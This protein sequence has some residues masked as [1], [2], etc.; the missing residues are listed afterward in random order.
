MKKMRF[1]LGLML[2]M[3]F[4]GANV[5]NAQFV[6]GLPS[7][8]YLRTTVTVHPCGFYASNVFFETWVYDP[9]YPHFPAAAE[10]P[11]VRWYYYF[12]RT[13]TIK[14]TS[15]T[16]L[17]PYGYYDSWTGS[18]W[19]VPTASDPLTSA[20]TYAGY[21][22]PGNFPNG[23]IFY[24]RDKDKAELINFFEINLDYDNGNELKPAVFRTITIGSWAPQINSN[25][26][27]RNF[28]SPTNIKISEMLNPDVDP[29][30]KWFRPHMDR[31][32]NEVATY[33]YFDDILPLLNKYP[34][35]SI[36]YEVFIKD[37]MDNNMDLDPLGTLPN[38]T[39]G[40][41]LAPDDGITTLPNH[42]SGAGPDLMF[43]A[44]KEN[45]TFKAFSKT[46]ITVTLEPLYES[47]A[48]RT[49]PDA[50]KAFIIV[51]NEDGSFDITIKRILFNYK[52]GISSVTSSSGD[53]DGGQTG[54]LALG[55]NFV[56]AALGTLYVQTDSPATLSIY[57]VTGQLFKQVSVSGNTTLPIP[58]GLYIVQL[59]GKAYKVIN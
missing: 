55:K 39:I 20:R 35:Y 5:A 25:K 11:L 14:L 54:N 22:V 10:D 43:Y 16:Q 48:Y 56:Y 15:S 47:D 9:V 21:H 36:E 53:G 41:Q 26:D 30:I 7:T 3:L 38:N 58:K 8:G 44:P 46:P 31:K 6:Y 57:S 19:W 52:I 29:N 13:S 27:R 32:S 23:N 2:S 18:D 40:V 12:D 42:L 50:D 24:W 59:N 37:E 51:D 1:T 45:W 33:L 17:I 28:L 34:I 49:I 4:L